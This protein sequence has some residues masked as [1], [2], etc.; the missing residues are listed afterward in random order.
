MDFKLGHYPVEQRDG[1]AVWHP[2]PE[3]GLEIITLKKPR[4][5]AS[6]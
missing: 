4:K 3:T 6:K 5:K 1:Y 2:A